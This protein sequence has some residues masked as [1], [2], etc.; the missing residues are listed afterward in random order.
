MEFGTLK[1]KDKNET[2]H[3]G[4]KEKYLPHKKLNQRDT[5]EKQ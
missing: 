2:H 1:A 5:G 3:G 4:A